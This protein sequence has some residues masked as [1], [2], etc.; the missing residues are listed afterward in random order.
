M[1]TS[2]LKLLSL[3]IKDNPKH[4]S[5]G[6]EFK[7]LQRKEARIPLSLG[8]LKVVLM[9]SNKFLVSGG[10]LHILVYPESA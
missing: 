6:G 4:Q 2:V 1:V 7:Y 10:L 5:I 9:I 3:V 8:K